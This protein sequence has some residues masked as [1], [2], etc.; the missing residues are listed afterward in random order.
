MG[1][2]A[3]LAYF[4]CAL[5][6]NSTPFF[7]LLKPQKISSLRSDALAS[8]SRVPSSLVGIVKP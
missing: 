6:L 8:L 3:T 2:L 7:T 4:L 1:F 5:F